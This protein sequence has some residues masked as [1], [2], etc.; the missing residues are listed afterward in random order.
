M[1]EL[2]AQLKPLYLEL[3]AFVRRKLADTYGEVRSPDLVIMLLCTRI[4]EIYCT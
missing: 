4:V 1:E 3:H 2:Y